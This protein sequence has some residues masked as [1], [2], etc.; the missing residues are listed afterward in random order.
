MKYLFSEQKKIETKI[1][2]AK[3]I[4]LVCDFDGTLVCIK[5]TPKLVRLPKKTKKLLSLLAKDKRNSVG[6]MSGRP[7]SEI[8][9]IIGLDNIFYTGN[10]GFEIK[11]PKRKKFI[12]PQAKKTRYLIKSLAKEFA[13]LL[14]G[15]K[16]LLI[17]DKIYTLSIHYR[18]C[19]RGQIA[20]LKKDVRRVCLPLIKEKKIRL[21]LGKK[22]IEIRPPV[23]WNKGKALSWIENKLKIYK[24]LTIYIGDDRTDEDAFAQ[25]RRGL[26]I[27]VGRKKKYSSAKFY[28]F[29]PNQVIEFLTFLTNL[30]NG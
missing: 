29:N 28:L 17:E 11:L 10:H 20:S 5:P 8:R 21:T 3:S 9:K 27:Y 18:N 23:D 7:L 16:G 25:I 4:L 12:H 26:A 6:I 14:S 15:Y 24:A 2:K 30:Q 1:R 13:G 22:V 19:L